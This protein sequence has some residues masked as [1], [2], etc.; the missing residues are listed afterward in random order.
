MLTSNKAVL[1]ELF[2]DNPAAIASYLTEKMSEN[3]LDAARTGL[4]LV[5]QAQNVQMLARDAGLRRDTLYRTFGGRIDPQLSRML[6]L[7]DAL[8]VEA[9]V[10]PA[11]PSE[12]LSRPS[13]MI[14]ETSN[15]FAQQLTKALAGNR[16]NETVLAL[17]EVVLSQNVSALARAS[18]IQRRT[19]YKTFGG[20]VDPQL[21]RILKLFTAM[22]LRFVVVPLPPRSRPPRPKLGRSSKASSPL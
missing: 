2:R 20:S 4:S 22:Q 17:R 10:V 16:F 3:D 9:G 21:S 11:N 13:S 14:A 18:G 7:Y 6:K 5:M 15:S 19:L 12:G 8:N 1:A